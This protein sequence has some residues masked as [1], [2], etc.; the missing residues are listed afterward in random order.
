MLLQGTKVYRNRKLFALLG[1]FLKGFDVF[2]QVQPFSA[3]RHHSDDGLYTRVSPG[4]TRTDQTAGK[5]VS[6]DSQKISY[7]TIQHTRNNEDTYENLRM[8]HPDL[9]VR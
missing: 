8:D 3:D 1:D 2:F 5:T 4:R 7:A 9:A 6:T